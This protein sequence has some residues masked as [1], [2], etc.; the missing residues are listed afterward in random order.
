MKALL[1]AFCL[2][3]LS[4][5][6]QAHATLLQ[7]DPIPGSNLASAPT[8]VRLTFNERV[9][10]LFNSLSVMSLSGYRVDD[11]DAHLAGDGDTLVVTLSPIVP[12]AYV[13]LWRVNS[14]D[15]HQV[16]GQFGFGF[17]SAAPDAAALQRFTMPTQSF[18]W[19]TFAVFMKWVSLTAVVVWLG[20]IFFLLRIAP[21]SATREENPAY[22]VLQKVERRSIW[23]LRTAAW[24]FLISEIVDLTAQ[25]TTFTGLAPT[26]ALTFSNLAAVLSHTNYGEW[27]LVRVAAAIPLIVLFA[28]RS[29]PSVSRA[30]SF[31]RAPVCMLLGAL[32]LLTWPLSGHAN[33]VARFTWLAVGMDWLHLAATS[34]WIGGLIHFVA[35]AGALRGDN[36]APIELLGQVTRRFSRVAKASVAVLLGSGIYNAWLHLPS[37]AAFVTTSYGRVLLAKLIVAV[38]ILSVAFVNLRRVLPALLSFRVRIDAA[39]V[40][41][42]RFAQLLRGEAALGIA[43]LALVAVLTSLPPAS[44]VS[45]GPVNLM[46]RVSGDAITVSLA[47][48]RVGPN[49]V[50]IS[51]LDSSHRKITDTKRVTAYLRMRDMDMGLTTVAAQPAEDGTYR[52]VVDLSMAGRWSLSVEVS[53]A[54]GDDFVAAFDFSCG[55]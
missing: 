12:G 45:T 40:W 7:T 41:A 27:W 23:L 24:T 2:C 34:V 55:F 38:L 26:R 18:S 14:A 52:A 10:P 22:D 11:G 43:I 13:V 6:A 54:N 1:V 4:A 29:S 5:D 48:N 28:I 32:V 21:V 39:R 47:P 49:T 33:A 8:Q 31:W 35:V 42:G 36:S 37:W 3:C 15:G 16:Q 30:Q 17:R 44:A 53:P 46:R 50:T 19:Q 9:E 51:L 25:T 20:G